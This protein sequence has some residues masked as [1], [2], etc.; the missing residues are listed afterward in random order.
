[1]RWRWR[2][3]ASQKRSSKFIAKTNCQDQVFQ[4]LF[5]LI[6]PRFEFCDLLTQ[7]SEAV[8]LSLKLAGGG[9]GFGL[10][11]RAAFERFHV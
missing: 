11:L 5:S 2:W 6:T 9:L 10:F 7:Y 3:S 1:M 4:F 8:L